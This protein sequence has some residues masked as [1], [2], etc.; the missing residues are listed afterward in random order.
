M[1]TLP[2]TATKPYTASIETQAPSRLATEADV[3][4]VSAALLSITTLNAG[5]TS[6]HIA[7]TADA[8]AASAI[9]NTPAG[10]LAATEVQ[11][12]LDEL[13]TDVDTRLVADS[14]VFIVPTSDPAVVGALWNDSGTLSIS[15]GA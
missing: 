6:D 5:A 10:N 8:H 13:Q 14:G 15:A 9:T 1:N 11:A 12:A 7:D 3:N 4:V 2:K